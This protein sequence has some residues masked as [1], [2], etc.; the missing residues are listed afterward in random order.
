MIQR[1]GDSSG[2][3]IILLSR[4]VSSTPTVRSEK[5][6]RKG[7]IGQPVGFFPSGLKRKRGR[8]G[9]SVVPLNVIDDFD[10][11]EKKKGK[12]NG[13]KVSGAGD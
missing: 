11:Q 2:L 8:K 3:P 10:R 6:E 13:K 5:E 4:P 12:K 1:E 9:K 7:K